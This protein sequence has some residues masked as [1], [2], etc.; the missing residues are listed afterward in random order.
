MRMLGKIFRAVAPRLAL[1][2]EAARVRL[3]A[4]E[5]TREFLNSGYSHHGASRQ[6]T[7]M[8]SWISTSKSPDE[9][10]G[11]NLELLRERSRDQYYGVPLARGAVDRIATSS[12]GPGLKPKFSINREY[13]GLSDDEADAWED[14]AER[15]FGY[16]AESKDCD[17]SR[18]C[19][20]YEMQALAFLGILQNGDVFAALPMK[21]LPGRLYDLRVRLIEGDRVCDPDRKPM[22]VRLCEGM[23]MDADGVPVAAWVANRHPKAEDFA[24]PRLEWARVPLFG[25]KSGR[26]NLLHLMRPERVDQPRGVPLLAP[27]IETLKQL[28]RYT[29]AELMASVVNGMYSIFFEHDSKE[30]EVGEESYAL[31]ESGAEEDI[32]GRVQLG[33]GSVFDLPPGVKANAAA[34]GR[35]N[36]AFDAFVLAVCRQVGAALGIPYELLVLNFT[37]SYS[38]SRGA[39]LEAWKLFKIWR[40]WFAGNFCQPILFEWLC[41]AVLKGRIDAPGFFEDP[42]AA[43]CYSWVDWYGPA[44]GQLDPLKEVNAAQK[45]IEINAS[46]ESREAMELTGSEWEMNVRLRAKEEAVK[47]ELKLSSAG[48]S[49]PAAVPESDGGGEREGE[50]A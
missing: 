5:K 12:V 49:E 24:L 7:S 50:E 13:L 1:K 45:R 22:G 28:G 48:Y 25:A 39:L 44:Q 10:I 2:R 21:P 27:V 11:Q 29:D 46:S 9:D 40:E 32:L 8:V 15:E 17:I 42:M 43:Y 33:Y 38:A 3:E 30:M 20:F 35:P 4:L 36:Q 47:K 6:R 18:R 14:H 34:P 31:D 19:N 26:R 16:W 37:S 23:E 41:E